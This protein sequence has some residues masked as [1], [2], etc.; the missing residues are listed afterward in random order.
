MWITLVA[1]ALPI[2]PGAKALPPLLVLLRRHLFI[3]FFL[4]AKV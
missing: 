3:D 2:T 1:L 4:L